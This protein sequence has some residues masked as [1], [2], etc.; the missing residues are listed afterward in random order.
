MLG[1]QCTTSVGNPV[2]A[3]LQSRNQRFGEV[4]HLSRIG[5]VGKLQFRQL[6]PFAPFVLCEETDGIG[7][8]Q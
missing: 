3:V 4:N 5:L 1:G 8:K 2:T 6:K 7:L